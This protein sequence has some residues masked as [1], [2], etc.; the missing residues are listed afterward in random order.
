MSE[1][2]RQGR[3][4]PPTK[5]GWQPAKVELFKRRIT[6]REIARD[7]GISHRH[8]ENALRGKAIPRPELRAYLPG[9]LHMPLSK[10]FVPE[11]LEHEYNERG[12]RK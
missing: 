3:P 10:L 6:A 11:V 1:S 4:E 7:L 9:L 12:T 5:F 2:A 8:V